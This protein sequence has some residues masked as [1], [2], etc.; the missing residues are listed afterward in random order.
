MLKNPGFAVVTGSIYLL[1]YCICIGVESLHHYLWYL[2]A[3]YP[4]MLVWVIYTIIRN[5]KYDGTE[6]NEEEWGYQ[7]WKKDELGII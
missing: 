7:D 6:L 5:G 3:L 1:F 4:I 2:F